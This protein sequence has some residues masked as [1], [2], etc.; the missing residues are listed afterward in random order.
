MNPKGASLKKI[1]KTVNPLT[2]IT[3]EDRSLHQESKR[4]LSVP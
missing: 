4:G 2:R 3:K 1:I